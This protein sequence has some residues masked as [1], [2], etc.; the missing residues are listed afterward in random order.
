VA[1]SLRQR[2]PLGSLGG[3][4]EDGHVVLENGDAFGDQTKWY[5]LSIPRIMLV[6]SGFSVRARIPSLFLP[7]SPSVA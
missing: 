5:L 4:G 3:G 6:P 7:V 1:G 2:N